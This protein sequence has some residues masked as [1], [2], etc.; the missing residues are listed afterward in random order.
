MAA[1]LVDAHVSTDAISAPMVAAL[2]AAWSAIRGRH[3]ELPAVVVVLGAES[4][5]TAGRL[6][7]G[8]FAAMRWQPDPTGQAGDAAAVRLPEVFIGGEGLARGPVGVLGTLLHEAAHALAQGP[9][10]STP[11]TSWGPRCG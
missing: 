4:I 6:R 3:P 1:G 7:L 9:P 5:G 11:S 10:T 8:H 2:E